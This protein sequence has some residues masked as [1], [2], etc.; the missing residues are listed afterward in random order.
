MKKII[1]L[2]LVICLLLATTSAYALN[3]K[4]I[5]NEVNDGK[6]IV[7]NTI[8]TEEYTSV[9][10][11]TKLAKDIKKIRSK[12]INENNLKSSTKMS[13]FYKKVKGLTKEEEEKYINL[14]KCIIDGEEFVRF[15]S[16]MVTSFSQGDVKI[17]IEEVTGFSEPV[18]D[19]TPTKNL[20]ELV[21]YSLTTILSFTHPA[22][23]LA[24]AVI[25]IPVP[26][27]IDDL[28]YYTN[29]IITNKHGFVLWEKHVK[30]YEN[31]DWTTYIIAQKRQTNLIV[32]VA[33]FEG[34]DNNSGSIVYNHIRD[35]Y[36]KNYGHDSI[37]KDAALFRS[38][39]GPY[40]VE[41]LSYWSGNEIIFTHNLPQ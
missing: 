38:I 1:S 18:V 10:Q 19:Q 3:D 30:V 15:P 40:N 16:T 21:A 4:N 12:L 23:A 33:W 6:K 7:K 25:G 8:T 32:D 5:N 27:N 2:I 28:A 24:C 34:T 39:N 29:C 37:L 14:E 36:A 9:L 13:S 17:D 41:I 11:N 22:V 26:N 35:E 20:D 31:N